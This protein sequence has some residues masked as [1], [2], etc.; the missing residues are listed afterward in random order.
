MKMNFIINNNNEL[1]NINSLF[2]YLWITGYELSTW[3]NNLG[4]NNVTDLQDKIFPNEIN[5]IISDEIVVDKTIEININDITKTYSIKQ[6]LQWFNEY[7]NERY[8][9]E[10][11]YDYYT[12]EINKDKKIIDIINLEWKYKSKEGSELKLHRNAFFL[13]ITCLI[14]WI[15]SG[16]VLF[17]WLSVIIAIIYLII[18]YKSLLESF[19]EKDLILLEKNIE[20]NILNAFLSNYLFAKD[21][22]VVKENKASEINWDF[23]VWMKTKD[24]LLITFLKK[25]SWIT[26]IT[27]YLLYISNNGWTTIIGDIMWLWCVISVI[28]IV[29]NLFFHIKDLSNEL[30]R[31]K[32]LKQDLLV[33]KTNS[34]YI[35]NIFSKYKLV[36]NNNLTVVDYYINDIFFIINKNKNIYDFYL[37][38]NPVTRI[39]KSITKYVTLL[40]IF[41]FWILL[42]SKIIELYPQYEDYLAF[43]FVIVWI[44]SFFIYIYFNNIKKWIRWLE[45]SE[46]EISTKTTQYTYSSENLEINWIW[47]VWKTIFEIFITRNPPQP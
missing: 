47:D 32:G 10:T 25:Y 30:D 21:E 40:L 42:Y 9:V 37:R 15:I 26:W 43:W 34:F 24:S 35:D 33:L 22:R 4:Y 6:V 12:N 29:I 5:L 38:Y 2:N 36:F 11:D 41:L 18:L 14:L 17:F 46:K 45:Y 3:N 39:F 31:F 13:W 23:L 8:D 28:F 19:T 27:I 16:S 1:E 7:F 44:I 20:N